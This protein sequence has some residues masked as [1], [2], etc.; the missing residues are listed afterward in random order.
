MAWR[1][2]L[3]IDQGSRFPW[4]YEVVGMSLVGLSA[5]M[6]IR[7]KGG[8]ALL[9]LDASSYLTVDAMNNQVVLDIPAAATVGATWRFGVYDIEVYHPTVSSIQPYRIVQGDVELDREVTF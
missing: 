4:I 1:Q 7:K 2:D 8:D 5:R 6:Q 3:V 9:L